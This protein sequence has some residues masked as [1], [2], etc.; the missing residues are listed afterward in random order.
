MSNTFGHLFRITTFGESHGPAIGVVIDGCP[1]GLTVTTSLI[2]KQLDKRKPGQ[3]AITTQRKED[4]KVE[5]LSGVYNDLTTGAPITLIIY[6]N[7][8]R[9]A[10]YDK[11]KDV[12]RPS[13]A[14]FTWE[15]KYGHRDHRGGGRLS[16]RE[17][18]ARVA[19]GAIAMELLNLHGIKINSYVSQVGEIKL[20]KHYR[21]LDLSKTESHLIR[22]PDPETA[23]EMIRL[24]E[25]VKEKGDTIGGTIS[26]VI[27]NPIVGLGE[28]VF[29]KLQAD[30]AKA[31]LSINAAHGFDYGG[32]FETI[33]K[34]GSELNDIFIKDDDN[35]TTKTNFSGGILGGISNG[36]DIYL[37]VLFKP[38]ATLQQP[39]QTINNEG[40]KVVIDPKG[41]HDPCVLPRAVPIVDAMAA[42]VLADH[43]LRNRASRL[44][45]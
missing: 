15:K 5:I 29:D 26:C 30:L 35:I 45:Y 12:Y 11:L 23:R 13:H 3:S 36:N 32:G 9:S 28:P 17:T 44:T 31:M 22:C 7:D 27:T 19:A 16:A 37:R 21:E 34:R 42:L 40:E 43:L 39:Q 25:T 20:R 18:A 2:Q 10:D 24:I 8:Q 1:A 4:D 38:V 14:D 33:E 6:N 41:R